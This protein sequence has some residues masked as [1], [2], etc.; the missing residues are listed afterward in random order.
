MV[1]LRFCSSKGRPVELSEEKPEGQRQ[2]GWRCQRC[3]VGFTWCVLL[4]QYT[5]GRNWEISRGTR[6]L[7]LVLGIVPEGPRRTRTPRGA[8]RDRS[9][10]WGVRNSKRSRL[11]YP[12]SQNFLKDRTVGNTLIKSVRTY[13]KETNGGRVESLESSEGQCERVSRNVQGKSRQKWWSSTF[14]MDRVSTENCH[15]LTWLLTWSRSVRFR[16]DDPQEHRSC[17]PDIPP[18]P[19][20]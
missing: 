10:P 4:D 7:F 17:A 5:K 12:E 13:T 3:V 20:K 18:V 15:R 19:R 8:W 1:V 16:S 6:I 9:R 2:D 14:V 11:E